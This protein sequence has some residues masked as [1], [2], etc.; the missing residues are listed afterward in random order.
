MSIHDELVFE[1]KE[2]EIVEMETLIKEE[3]EHV[4][5]LDVPLKVSLGKGPNWAEAHE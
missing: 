2:A 1:V 4:I 5:T 3:M